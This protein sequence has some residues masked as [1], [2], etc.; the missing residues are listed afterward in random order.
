MNPVRIDVKPLSVN[1]AWQGRRY[2][3]D[4]YECYERK[5]LW[6]L[7]R[8]KLPEPPF[9]VY[10]EYGFSNKRSDYDNPT[11]MFQDILQKKYKF[12]DDDIYLATI[13]KV[14]VKKGCEYVKFSI[15]HFE[16]DTTE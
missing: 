8:I 16:G 11:K 3:T 12:N 6:L 9:Q 7:P 13:R 2:K 14:V 5:M 1:E 10:Y 4:K 15:E